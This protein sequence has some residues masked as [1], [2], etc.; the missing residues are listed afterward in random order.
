MGDNSRHDQGRSWEATE[1]GE[2]ALKAGQTIQ[3]NPYPRFSRLA[4]A[5]SKGFKF[6]LK[7]QRDWIKSHKA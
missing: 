4:V 6:E 5:W 7:R 1:E 3:S 2:R